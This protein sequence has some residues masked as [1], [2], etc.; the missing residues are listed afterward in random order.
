MFTV[1]GDGAA[2]AGKWVPRGYTLLTESSHTSRLGDLDILFPQDPLLVR[3]S[4][5]RDVVIQTEAEAPSNYSSKAPVNILRL[6][7]HGKHQVGA[8]GAKTC[9]DLC[10]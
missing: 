8:L 10:R 3:I 2:N 9:E 6:L 4:I 5:G 1:R 7:S